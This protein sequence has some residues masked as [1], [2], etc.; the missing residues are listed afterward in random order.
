MTNYQ[1]IITAVDR[2][3]GHVVRTPLIVSEPMSERIGA[4]IAIKAEHLQRTG[5]FKLRG[6]VNKV[7]S[8]ADEAAATGVV[9]ASSGNHGIGVATAAAARGIPC[10]VY[11]PTGASSAKVA[12]IARL[13]AV[14]N[15]VDDTDALVAEHAARD[16]AN[17]SGVTYISPY[18]DPEVIAGQGTIGV[19]IVE[20]AGGAGLGRLDAVVVSVGG[21]GLISGVATAVK[22]HH[23][24]AVIV[25]ASA[26]NDRAMAASVDAGHLIEPPAKPTF[27]DGTAGAVETGSI[28]FELCRSLV[29]R[30]L[31]VEE[32]AIATAV[33]RMIDDHHQL[34]EGSAGMA[35]AAA[36]HYGRE[37][38]GA[39]MAVIS[40]G[41]NASAAAI[42]RMLDVAKPD[43]K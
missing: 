33:A 27:S 4:T 21:G 41:A 22:Q 5:S 31:D 13:G 10:T 35:L 40:C 32:Q 29:D 25:A 3:D 43:G 11:L 38:P 1:D 30:W 14:I 2:I 9:T 23:P 7:F 20:D 24:D 6:A 28:T 37:N 42:K 39:T 19:E 17:T 18:N 34:V 26:L 15:T 16:A 8:L 12:A 36:A